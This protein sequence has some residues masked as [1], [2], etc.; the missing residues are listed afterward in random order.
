MEAA[1]VAEGE[2]VGKTKLNAHNMKETKL[3]P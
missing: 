2:G 1:E 3:S